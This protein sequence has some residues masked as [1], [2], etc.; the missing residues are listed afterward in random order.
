MRALYLILPEFGTQ[1]S[2]DN[3]CKGRNAKRSWPFR[4]G[5]RCVAMLRDFKFIQERF[6][7]QLRNDRNLARSYGK[8]IKDLAPWQW[9]V[10]PLTF[11]DTQA[12]R[13]LPPIAIISRVE[14]FLSDLQAAAG[15]PICWVIGEELG[16][17]GGRV[18]CHLLISGVAHL[19]PGDWRAE[20]YRRFGFTRIEPYDPSRRGAYYLA[21]RVSGEGNIHFGGMLSQREL[22]ANREPR[23]AVN[24]P[25]EV[26]EIVRSPD[27]ERDFFKMGLPRWHR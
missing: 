23:S 17:V 13:S 20:A 25:D 8:F 5:T 18:H 24:S 10:N 22:V 2:H 12:Q 26:K 7:A 21:K 6:A 9:F 4:L 11:R 14:M 16:R 3:K 19:C 15:N 27:M 1:T